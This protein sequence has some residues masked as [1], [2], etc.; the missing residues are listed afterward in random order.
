MSS[1]SPSSG[2]E[3]VLLDTSAAIAFLDVEDPDC[4]RVR[5]ALAGRRL[6]LAGHAEFES[7]SVL[8]RIAPPKRLTAVA[9]SR[10]LEENFPATRHLGAKAAAALRAEFTSFGIDGGAVFDGLVAAAAREHALTLVTR[11]RRAERTYRA[12]GVTYLML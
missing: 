11:D 9:V 6:G 4:D 5:R 2:A 1:G 8:T 12:L 3:T 10:L 7:F